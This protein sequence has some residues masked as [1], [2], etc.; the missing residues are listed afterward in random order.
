MNLTGKQQKIRPTKPGGR[1]DSLFFYFSSLFF[2]KFLQ[3]LQFLQ[4]NFEAAYLKNA[5]ELVA[6]DVRQ[7][8]AARAGRARSQAR[9]LLDKAV[10]VVRQ[11]P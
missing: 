3:F 2:I 4:F 7:T 11:V 5:R 1:A 6:R 9:G 8:C 10:T